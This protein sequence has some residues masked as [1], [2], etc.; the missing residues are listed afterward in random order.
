MTANK[1][2]T[3]EQLE[4][5]MTIAV[6]MQRDSEMVSDRPAAMFAYAVQVAVLELRKVRNEA[7]ALAAEN[8]GLKNAITAVSKTSEECEINGDELK[9]VVEPSEFDALTDLLDETPVTDA[10][11]AE[12]RAQGVTEYASKRGF[13][14]QHGSIHAHFG[15]GDVMVGA[16]TFENGD[17]G[18]NF[19][20][21]REKTGGVGTSYEW[22]RGKTAE[23]V[24]SVFV[25]ASSNAEG[26][27]VI[28][29]KLSEIIASLR[30]GVQS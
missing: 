13:S 19:A 26:L 15:N 2:M 23:Q 10:F 3:S 8:A 21:V 22:T 6:N 29:D 9:Y 20:P 27:E 1:P 11:M 17:A 30:K 4:E 7:A 12:M 5:L 25:I 24:D 14:F 28:R 18:I 16:V